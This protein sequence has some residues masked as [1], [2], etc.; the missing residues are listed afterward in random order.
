MSDNKFAQER[1]SHWYTPE[2]H[3]AHVQPDGKK[4]TLRHARKLG[5]LPSVTNILSSLPKHAVEDWRVEQA[6][7][8]TMQ[9]MVEAGA[10][11][12]TAD[13]MMT[14][15]SQRLEENTSAGRRFGT[16]MHE[17]IEAINNTGALPAPMSPLG[18]SH[19]EHARSYL[20]WFK[21]NKFKWSVH[22][23][24]F[25][26]VA[27]GI[28]YGGCIDFQAG[29]E[30]GRDFIIDFKTQAVKGGK[31]KFYPEWCYQLAAYDNGFADRHR[32][33]S[34][35]IDS[36]PSAEVTE[37]EWSEEDIEEGLAVFR[38]AANLWSVVRGYNPATVVV[39]GA[40]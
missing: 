34:V 3:S 37:H 14:R 12:L 20:T 26:S 2:G 15:V 28:P 19:P 32:L 7:I 9:C 18:A 4:T 1:G 6:V 29:N 31:P 5:L 8:S 13:E 24:A 16:E 39:G 40:K 25:K 27:G 21:S 11:S 36:G 35:V 38:A 22:E 33:V 17:I 10:S 30:G 23:K